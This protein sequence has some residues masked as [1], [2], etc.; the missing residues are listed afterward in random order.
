MSY[1]DCYDDFVERKRERAP[2]TGFEIN[3][4]DLNPNLFDYQAAVTRWGIGKGNYLGAL[5]VGMGK[6]IL[7]VEDAKIKQAQYGG[8]VLF[9][10]PLAVA[11]Q[12]ILEAK[13]LNDVDPI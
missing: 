6:T 4:A 5:A 10:A 9:I 13:R 1:D 7:Q 2:V 12:T 11:H 3:L 8:N